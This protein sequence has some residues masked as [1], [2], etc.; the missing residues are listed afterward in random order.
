M[1]SHLG[2]APDLRHESPRDRGDGWHINDR[3]LECLDSLPPDEARICGRDCPD[4]TKSGE[5]NDA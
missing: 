5:K 2:R 4:R 3:C 1:C